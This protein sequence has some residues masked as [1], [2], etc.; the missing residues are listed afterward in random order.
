MTI[1]MTIPDRVGEALK[2]KG[3]EY[4]QDA[5]GY[6]K[7]MLFAAA[8]SPSGVLLKLDLPPPAVDPAQQLLPL[9]GDK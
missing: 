3:L 6:L 5:T 7:A 4:G 2:K 1:T 8:H 9:T